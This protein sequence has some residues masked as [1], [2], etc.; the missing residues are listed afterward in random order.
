MLILDKNVYDFV[1]SMFCESRTF[2]SGFQRFRR[3]SRIS[4]VSAKH[5]DRCKFGLL[6]LEES[7]QRVEKIRLKNNDWFRIVL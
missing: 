7:E 3:V 5:E 1:E 4:V 6:R 2:V